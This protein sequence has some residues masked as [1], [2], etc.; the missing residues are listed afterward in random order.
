M[1]AFLRIF[2]QR[3][4]GGRGASHED[5]WGNNVPYREK[6]QCKI[7]RRKA[8]TRGDRDKFRNV[9]RGQVI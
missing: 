8:T 6:P 3:L 1:T 9:T 5:I 2:E 7:G 4:D